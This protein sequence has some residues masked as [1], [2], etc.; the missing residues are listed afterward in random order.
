M[1]TAPS[2]TS[3]VFTP[4][5]AVIAISALPL[6]VN[7]FNA[8]ADSVIAIFTAASIATVN[9][10]T[11]ATLAAP[12]TEASTD[13]MRIPFDVVVIDKAGEPSSSFTITKLFVCAA[14]IAVATEELVSN[15]LRLSKSSREPKAS[16][17]SIL[18]QLSSCSSVG[19]IISA[20]G[21]S[22]SYV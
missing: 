21:L 22:R 18:P 7:T 10:A 15:R 16:R 4:D 17:A 1:L 9:L 3:I 14:V 2:I 5:V 13:C 19:P 8:L 20:I 11:A 6:A 12:V